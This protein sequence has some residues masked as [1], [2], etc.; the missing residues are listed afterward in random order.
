MYLN[1][2]NGE[3]SSSQSVNSTTFTASGNTYNRN[4]TDLIAYCFASKENMSKVGSYTGSTSAVDVNTGFEPAF[5]MIKW[6]S[7]SIGYGGWAIYDN[8]R[9]TTSP[10]SKLLQANANS[11]ELDNVSY[12]I[13]MTS[14]G[15]TVGS[16]QND[17][18]NYNGNEYIYYAIANTI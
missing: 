10:N 2:T 18:I 16:T 3:S 17:A 15:F 12:S 9:D 1:K 4:G 14:T 8:K 13:T 5:V 7:G 6:T 11:Q